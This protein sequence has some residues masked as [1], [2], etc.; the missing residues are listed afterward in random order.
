MYHISHHNI[1]DNRDAMKFG[2]FQVANH[3]F[4]GVILFRGICAVCLVGTGYPTPV[5]LVTTF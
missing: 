1:G 2:G 5:S 3:N 4:P